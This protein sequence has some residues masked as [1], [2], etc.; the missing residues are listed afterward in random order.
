M[1]SESQGTVDHDLEGRRSA[2]TIEAEE[3]LA[4]VRLNPTHRIADFCAKSE[5]VARFLHEQAP[6]WV[7]QRYCGV[8]VLPSADDPT[9]VLGY[10]T[11]SQFVLAREEL[12]GKHRRETVIGAIPLVLIGFMGKHDGAPMGLGAGLIVDAARRAH[13]NVDVPACGL[14]VEPEGGRD[15]QKLWSWYEAV[16]FIPAKTLPR[17]MYAPYESLIPELTTQ[18][19]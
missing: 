5:R 13:R 16:G 19:K 8:F 6:R 14:A 15:N 2:S 10:Y 9:Q 17:L 12:Q 1:H 7:R 18:R 3:P 4:T 11:L